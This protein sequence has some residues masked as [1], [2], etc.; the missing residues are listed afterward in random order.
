MKTDITV[1]MPVYN[2]EKYLREAI[3]SVLA[4]TY[5]DFEFL[6]VN[7]GSTDNSLNIIK[8]YSDKRIR[9]INRENGGVSAA[10]NTGLTTAKGSF[11]VRFD[12]DDVCYPDRIRLQYEF[13]KKNPE[14]VLAGSDAD[15]INKDGEYIFTFNN[16]GYTDEVIR[17]KSLLG[18]PF[19]HSTVIYRKQ[20]VLDLGGYEVKAHT[21]E[22]YFLWIQLLKKGKVCNFD[23]PLIKVRFNPESVTVDNRDY[24]YTFK[25]LHKKALKTG[26]ITEDEG[27]LILK[28]INKLSNDKKVFSYNRMLAKKYLWNNY[29]PQ[30]AR[31]H[32]IEALKI[33]PLDPTSYILWLLS[34]LPKEIIRVVYSLLS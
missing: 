7:D 21:F 13:M 1:L 4:Q 9:L 15:Y 18:C 12:A 29:Q 6:I 31:R 8:S 17:E 2:A 23:F 33:K 19:I 34:F 25:S 26:V 27:K 10:L 30:K 3:D 16:A 14:Y 28:S 22:D 11:I 24:T 5:T 20:D 32:I